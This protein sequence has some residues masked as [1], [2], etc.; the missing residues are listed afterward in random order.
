M[1]RIIPA[2]GST[3]TNLQQEWAYEPVAFVSYGGVSGGTRSVQ[4][5]KQIV[6]SLK[7]MPMAEAVNLPFFAQH[8]D[9]ETRVFTPPTVQ[10]D[11]ARAMLDETL[12][13]AEA[14]RPLRVGV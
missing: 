10:D 6:P 3:S 8:L 1:S 11:A 12:R 7:M 4:M 9:T 13:W 2:S 14:L 5:T